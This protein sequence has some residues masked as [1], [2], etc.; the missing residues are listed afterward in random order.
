M[1][2]AGRQTSC[3]PNKDVEYEAIDFGYEAVAS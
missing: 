3:C 1:V 2:E